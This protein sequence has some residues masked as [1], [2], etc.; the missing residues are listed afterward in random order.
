[1]ANFFDQFD[2]SAAAP[3]P[4]ADAISKVES[5]GNYRAIGPN[6]DEMGRAL[7]KYQVMSANVGPWSKEV[8]GREVTPQEFVQSPE[9]QD[10]IFNGK[11]GSVR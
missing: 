11:F 2:S 10:A 7:G 1:V 9:I 4:Y 5:G 3:S 6:T 8:L